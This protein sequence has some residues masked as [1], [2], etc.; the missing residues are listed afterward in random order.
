MRK[1]KNKI[2]STSPFHSQRK[3]SAIAYGLIIMSVVTIILVSI[4]QYISS[5]IRFSS[6][7]LE[8]E[9]A[10]QVA[11]AGISYYRWYLAHEISG[12]SS[13][14]IKDFW[15][16]GNPYGV[17]SP[18]EAE[19]FDPES[20]AIGKYK[21][22]VDPPNP[23]STIVYLKSTG[24]TYR[25][26]NIKRTI[27]VRLRRP[28][29]SEY[30]VLANDVMRFG[31]NTEVYGR[32]HS[33]FGIRFDGLAHNV[34]ASSVDQYDDPDHS[35]DN[36]FGVHTHVDENGG[37]VGNDFQAE[38]APPL[39]VPSRTDVFE[40]GR[41][42]PVPTVNFNGLS[43]DLAYMKSESQVPGHGIYYD[44]SECSNKTNYGRH[45]IISGGTMTVTTVTKYNN[46]NFSI[47]TEGCTLNNVEIPNDG[48]VFVENNLWLEGT[49]NN[50]R[51]TFV[52]A[53][54]SGGEKATVYI[55]MDNILYTNY[56]C[57][58]NIGIIAQQDIE[59][60]KNS[61]DDLTIEAA[62]I[63]QSGKVGRNYYTPF[64]C[65]SQSCEDHKGTITI[66]GAM[67]TFLRYGFA[68]TNG[69]GYSQRILN[70]SNFLLYCPPPYFPTGSD[71]SVD[72]WEEL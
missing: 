50:K 68:Y 21:I 13:E 4:L 66:N 12:K 49:I 39:L 58:D 18:Y 28:S 1:T 31:E 15:E 35:G 33:N 36:E 44:N 56:E 65:Q 3:G 23:G 11:E 6:N 5:Q 43:G 38:E 72:L 45:I 55:G 52:A 22:E 57:S 40:A 2:N 34:V 7:R 46:A 62:L 60:I 14:Q 48:V 64:G 32:V 70:F 41:E 69:T 20:G 10:F 37:G 63:S 42:F 19:F 26:P 59:V 29:W 30:A 8:R 67:A 71:Y 9:K 16:S 51:V 24:W 61:L 17:A 25:E 54:L 27:Q 47:Q 53:N